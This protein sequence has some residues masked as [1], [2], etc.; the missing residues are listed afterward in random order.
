MSNTQNTEPKA[1][2]KPSFVAYNVIDLGEGKDSK[3][4]EI[5]VGF[6]HKDGNGFDILIDSVPLSGKITLRVP[7]PKEVKE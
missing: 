6:A 5:G 1:S 3:W 2:R 7:K 4:R